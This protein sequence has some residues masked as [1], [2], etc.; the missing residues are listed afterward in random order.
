MVKTGWLNIIICMRI[1]LQFVTN[2]RLL[3]IWS[4]LSY[5]IRI[6]NVIIWYNDGN[7]MESMLNHIIQISR[8]SDFSSFLI[9]IGYVMDPFPF[10]FCVPIL[11][12]YFLGDT[13]VI[14]RCRCWFK[15]WETL[16]HKNR[17]F[18]SSTVNIMKC[19]TFY[20]MVFV[21]KISFQILN[22]IG[23]RRWDE[24]YRPKVI[25]SFEI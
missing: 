18:F 9:P 6:E 11:L 12:I 3:L 2:C 15:I 23:R 13:Y 8:F 21:W 10:G 22:D 4:Y 1:F 5:V 25:K 7:E 19:N 16:L 20:K 14:W 24:A 17:W